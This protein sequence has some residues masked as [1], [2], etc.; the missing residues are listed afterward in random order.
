[1]K[2]KILFLLPF[3]SI[4]LFSCKPIGDILPITFQ[5]N[6]SVYLE[7]QSDAFKNY[8]ISF[9]NA[10]LLNEEEE[11]MS[12]V[13]SKGNASTVV[14][15]TNR[16]INKLYK[17]YSL[18]TILETKYNGNPTNENK[19]KYE[20][21][22]SYKNNALVFYNN[23]LN[24]ASNSSAEIK[25]AFFGNKTDAE[26][27]EYLSNGDT[28]QS[29][30]LEDNMESIQDQMSLVYQGRAS[31]PN[32]V[33][34]TL[35]LYIDYIGY[36]NQ[37][38]TLKGY[39]DYYDYAYKDI[40]GRDYTSSDLANLSTYVKSNIKPLVSNFNL[41]TSLDSEYNQILLGYLT[42]ANFA[43]SNTPSRNMYSNFAKEMGD[44]YTL[45]FNELW[46]GGYYYFS[47]K[48]NSLSTAYV[49][50]LTSE[51]KYLM[52]FSRNYQDIFT[53]IHEFGH[54]FALNNN[55]YNSSR[56]MDI[57]ET[58]STGSEL[59]FLSYYL[60]NAPNNF[61]DVINVYRNRYIYSSLKGILQY[62]AISEIEKYAYKTN[63]V[64][65]ATL[66]DN[67]R[68]I[69]ES[70][71]LSYND[72]SYWCYPVVLAPCYY[73]SYAT[74]AI[75][76]LQFYIKARN[77]FKDTVNDYLSLVNDKSNSSCV[78]I[79]EQGNIKS[80]FVSSAYNGFNNIFTL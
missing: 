24:A 63:W 22:K 37:L 6:T 38:A 25:R 13:T 34:D 17:L 4:V 52:Y 46:D 16:F 60:D 29:I 57:K 48:E 32:Y 27:E 54:Y 58:H 65:K 43:N 78:S 75:C 2:N 20:T 66:S 73:V 71:G 8:S 19:S 1:M 33:S 26:I 31:N 56:A 28:P 18:N 76:A 80:P 74:S 3:S 40:F 15:K 69:W 42:S 41:P 9:N 50:S 45:C 62:S 72:N 64:N 70:Y 23:L 36:A 55:S 39:D 44:Q 51:S 12:L 53:I 67:I 35:D 49:A 5:G 7:T 61:K 11:L 47:S 68:S 77:N 14:N 21:Y 59:L 79:W 10:E 30:A